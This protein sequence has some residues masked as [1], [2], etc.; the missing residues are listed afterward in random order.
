MNAFL[1]V[2]RREFLTRVRKKSFLVMT[3]LGPIFFAALMVVP[4]LLEESAE[5]TWHILVLD[6]LSLIHI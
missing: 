5:R 3:I 4:V 2:A 1:L 6:N